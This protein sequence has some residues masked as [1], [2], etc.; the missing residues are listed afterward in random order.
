RRLHIW[1]M[2]SARLKYV[3]AIARTFAALLSVS[4]FVRSTLRLQKAQPKK[5]P[6]WKKGGCVQ[7]HKQLVIMQAV[8][9]FDPVGIAPGDT[10][11]YFY[12][13]DQYNL[14]N[15]PQGVYTLI[16]PKNLRPRVYNF[17]VPDLQGG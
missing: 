2:R 10:T 16:P 1:P 13:E 3:F 9:L 15:G 11:M 14:Q 5:Q 7:F 12:F 8:R 17:F 4:L 6:A